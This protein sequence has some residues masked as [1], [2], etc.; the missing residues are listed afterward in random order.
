MPVLEAEAEQRRAT[1]SFK[2]VA[3]NWYQWWSKGV[4]ADTAAYIFRRLEADVFPD[5]GSMPVDDI[6]AADIRRLILAIEERGARDVAQ[7]QHGTISQIFR[8]AVTHDLAERNP[9]ADFKPS[10]VLSPR[11]TQH[12]AHIHPSGLPA[13]LVAM[14]N[15][16]GKVVVRFALKL[17]ALLFVR[18]AELLKAPWSEFDLNNGRWVITPER[19]KM[20]KPHIVPLTRQAIEILLELKQLAGD[21]KFVFPGMNKQ[22]QNGTINC[23]SLLNALD[24]CGYK[25]DMTGHGYRALAR[26]VLAEN[27]FK[28]EHVELQ[29][30]H[31]NGDK[32][33]SAYNHALY[34][35]QRTEMMQWWADYLDAE[36]AKGRAKVVPLRHD[37]A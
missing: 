8:Y 36:L 37:A 32:V 28:K 4:D 22:T 10:D 1:N 18:S 30:S 12:R 33:E 6:K 20:D 9:A 23:N 3:L 15:Y 17:M 13:L 21:K 24:D 29:L 5:F 35:P 14:D 7:R 31:S 11:R 19:M 2:A 27:G 34:I 25:A 26:T 16:D